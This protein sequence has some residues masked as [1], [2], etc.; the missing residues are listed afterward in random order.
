M[1]ARTKTSPAAT[2]LHLLEAGVRLLRAQGFHGTTVDGICAEAGVTKGGF[3]HYFESKEDLARAAVEQFYETRTEL[4]RE[5]PFRKLADPLARV[6]GRLDFEQELVEASRQT[7]GCLVGMF[8]QEVAQSH[9]DLRKACEKYFELRVDDFTADLAAAKEAHAPTADFDPSSLSWHYTA[10][11]QGSYI[12]AKAS[13]SNA[14]RL[15]GLDH[16]R[17][18]L[19]FLFG[20]ETATPAKKK[21]HASGAKRALTAH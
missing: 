6:F 16:F 15:E 21:A 14:I 3:F 12:L 4:F 10:I 7:T 11:V 19:R 17:R 2:K 20:Q 18:Y 5:A 1:S 9:R 13:G 8:A